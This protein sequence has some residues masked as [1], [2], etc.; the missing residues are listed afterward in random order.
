MIK[1]DNSYAYL[2]ENFYQ[3]IKPTAVTKPE[4]IAVNT[5]LLEE[6]GL[7]SKL[8]DEDEHVQIF[9][10]N[11]IATGSEPIALAYAGH[12]FG[13]FVPKLGDG[14]AILLGEI[15][16]KNAKRKDIQLK[17]SGPTEFSRRGDGRASLGPV[18]REYIV[19]HAMHNFNV[20]T[21]RSL[22]IIKTGEQILRN[23]Y[24]PGAILVRVAASHLRIGT[25]EYF[26]SRKDVVS[27]KILADYAINRHYQHLATDEQPYARLLESVRDSQIE[28][29]AHWMQVGFI[30]G[31]MNTD[32]M[33]ISGETIDYGPCAFLDIYNPEKVFSS[34]DHYGRYAY[35]NQPIIGKWNL[36]C[37][38]RCLAPL[39]DDNAQ[40]A[41]AIINRVL[42]AYEEIFKQQWL[43]RMGLKIGIT[44]LQSTDFE[45]I[46]GLLNLMAK[47]QTDFTITFRSL[48]EVVDEQSDLLKF[49]LLFTSRTEID[50]WLKL[51][52]KRLESENKSVGEITKIMQ[53][54]N[55][56]YIP[57][58]HLIEQAIIE[59]VDSDNF[60]PMEKL[61]K[62]LSNPFEEDI[63]YIEYMKP[64]T[65]EERVYQTFCGT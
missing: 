44:T 54:V 36:E 3:K 17:G 51:W 4:V 8:F 49:H 7:D 21:T 38:A 20:P 11:K 34:I 26:A 39:I 57:R 61:L 33:T 12:Q 23:K 62:V 53:S 27:L 14:R 37:L 32:N 24:E 41:Q 19:S 9:A 16:D 65:S 43:L 63:D 28:L 56:A 55:P 10:G 6:L 18:M 31:V 64:P 29:I 2:P 50:I 45:L 42:E 1:F 59:A 25:F 47:Y 30:H 58:N 35:G 5:E 48:C 22:A 15:I 46:N 40:Q 52:R 13:Y 60:V